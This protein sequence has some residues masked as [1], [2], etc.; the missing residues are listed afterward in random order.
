MLGEIN[1]QKKH[2]EEAIR[3]Y[4]LDVKICSDEKDFNG[5]IKTLQSIGKL[6]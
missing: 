1:C 4:K 3:Y 6:Y 5:M 2:Y